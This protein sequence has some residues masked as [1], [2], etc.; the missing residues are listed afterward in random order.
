MKKILFV[1]CTRADYGKLKSIILNTQKNKKFNTKVF[2]S[3]M[4]NLKKYGSTYQELEVDK[5]KGI[6]RYNN[7]S[8]NMFMDQNFIN[9]MKGFSPFIMKYKP[10]LV[11]IH[12]DR[13]EAL[14]CALTSIL[15]NFRIVHIEGGELSGTLDEMLRH[16]ISKLSHIHFVSNHK[17]KKR[18][19]QMGE[20]KKKIFVV[21]SPDIDIILGKK[22]PKLTVTKNRYDINFQNFNLAILHPVTTELQQQKKNA[23]IF[24]LSLFLSKLNYIIVLPNND[25]GSE[26]II[27]ELKKYKACKRFKIFPSLRFEHYLTILKNSN[28]IIGNSSSGIIEAPYYNTKTINIGSRQNK[29]LESKIII[30]INFNKRDILNCIKKAL[31]L[32]NKKIKKNFGIGNSAKKIEKIFLTSKIW[33]IPRQKIFVDLKK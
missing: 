22:L 17:A 28:F 9:T 14:A 7:Q 25:I 19:V 8:R 12:G 30:N 16:S 32:K 2:V 18:L 24:F 5:I 4:H 10:D 13:I 29:R 3:G 31:N 15:N 1:T 20:D 27:K 26:I 11:V 33:N 6:Y 21:G 23:K